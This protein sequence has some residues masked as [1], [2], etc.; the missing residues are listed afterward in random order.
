M[1]VVSGVGV[2]VGG[3]EEWLGGRMEDM[4]RCVGE[5]IGGW[6]SLLCLASLGANWKNTFGRLGQEASEQV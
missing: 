4:E 5:V 1:Y 3:V 6:T 2:E